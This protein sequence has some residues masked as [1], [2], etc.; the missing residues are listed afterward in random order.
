MYEHRKE[1]M[2][3]HALRKELAQCRDVPKV[4]P[5]A[6]A[7]QREPGRI[8]KRLYN[9]AEEREKIREF[10]NMALVKEDEARLDKWF[11]PAIS[12]L[13]NRANTTSKAVRHQQWEHLR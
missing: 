9:L 11:K 3:E 4:S 5:M 2:R 13:G 1:A 7:I 8:I 6:Q 10:K 12:S